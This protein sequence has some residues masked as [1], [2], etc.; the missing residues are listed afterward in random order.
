L[1]I[2][3]PVTELNVPLIDDAVRI[4]NVVPFGGS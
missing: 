1:P 3:A 2:V 4:V